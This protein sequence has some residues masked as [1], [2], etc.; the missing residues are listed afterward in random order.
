MSENIMKKTRN[1]FTEMSERDQ[2]TQAAIWA[3]MLLAGEMALALRA[4][5]DV[6]L[7]KGSLDEE[8]DK[9]L[10]QAI[11]DGGNLRM[12]YA[13]MENIFLDKFSRVKTALSNPEVAQNLVQE[14]LKKRGPAVPTYDPASPKASQPEET[15]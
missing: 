6:L 11:V 1:E 9:I 10:N 2:D 14:A 4:L 7:T 8:D 12:A 5:R 13:H 15:S 3:L